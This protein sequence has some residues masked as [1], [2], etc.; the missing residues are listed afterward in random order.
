MTSKL[1]TKPIFNTL[2]K[3]IK[4]SKNITRQSL[5]AVLFAFLTCIVSTMTA[6]AELIDLSDSEP[7]IQLST[8][9]ASWV[10]QPSFRFSE[11]SRRCLDSETGEPMKV[12]SGQILEVTLSF[13]VDK[14]G[15]I[16]RVNVEESSGNRCLDRSAI[17]QV[18]VGRFRPFMKNGKAVLAQVTLPI[19]FVIP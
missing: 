3:V 16:T 13:L 12:S 10:K 15:S 18:K 14:Q 6:Q 8:K 5:L 11:R 1:H 19:K 7:V 2:H 9:D 4:P 17:Q